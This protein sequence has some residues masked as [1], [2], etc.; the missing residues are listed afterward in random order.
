MGRKKIEKRV[1]TVEV[2]SGENWNL[3]QEGTHVFLMS[4]TGFYKNK[5]KKYESVDRKLVITVE[6]K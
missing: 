5:P 6:E 4:A 3:V 1:E 2:Y